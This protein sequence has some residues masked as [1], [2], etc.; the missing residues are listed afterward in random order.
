M[1]VVIV[2]YGGRIICNFRVSKKF[3]WRNMYNKDLKTP[4]LQNPKTL[5]T[6]NYSQRQICILLQIWG[7]DERVEK[8]RSCFGMKL[9]I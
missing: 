5:T 2:S 8:I 9:K 4:K 1:G 7:T 6:R 3:G